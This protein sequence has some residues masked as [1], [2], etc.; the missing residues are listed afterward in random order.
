[1]RAPISS[2]PVSRFPIQRY[3]YLLISTVD[4]VILGIS[5]RFEE[6]LG[7]GCATGYLGR[8]LEEFL[9]H[10]HTHHADTILAAIEDVIA[11]RSPRKLIL[12]PVGKKIH[13]LSIYIHKDLLY[14][15]WEE[16]KS[17]SIS[18]TEMDEIGFL[19]EKEPVDLWSS[20]CRSIEKL[21]D[22]DRIF[23][24]QVTDGYRGKVVAERAKDGDLR[25]IQREFSAAFM[26]PDIIAYYRGRSFRYCPDFLEETQGFLTVQP[27]IDLVPS[28][29]MPI[30]QL[31]SLYLNAIGV[32]S[33]IS[34]SLVINGDFWGLVICQNTAKKTI[35]FQKRKLCTFIV[36]NVASRFET[37]VKQKLLQY[38]EKISDVELDLKDSFLF[39][40]TINCALV[41]RMEELCDIPHA[42][43]LALYHHGDIFT[44]GVCPSKKQIR[45]IV[46]FI[47]AQPKK[48]IFKDNNFKASHGK[49]ISG[50]LPFAGLIAL[51]VGQQEDHQMIW[52]RCESLQK[53]TQIEV[54]ADNNERPG[55]SNADRCRIWENTV[56]GSAIPWNENELSFVNDLHTLMIEAIVTRAKEQEAFNQELIS[57]NNELE[58]LTFTLSHDLRSPLAIA[59]MG[60]QFMASNKELTTEKQSEWQANILENMHSIE[61]IID[62]A[63]RVSSTRSYQFSKEPV[64]MAHMIRMICDNAKLLYQ[65][66]DC[67]INFGKLLPLW[68]EKSSLYQIFLNII[69]NGVKYSVQ[70]Q[71]PRIQIKS[72]KTK[73]ATIYMITDNGI[74]IPP[75]NLSTV[76]DVFGRAGNTGAYQ[77]TGIGL[78]LARRILNRLGG[79][80]E[81]TSDVGQGTT[82]T[83]QFPSVGSFPPTV[84]N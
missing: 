3:G 74:G 75:E 71:P 66:P 34:F 51:Q 72:K 77:G 83:L 78:S 80:I 12:H 8:D 2:M 16:Q 62:G 65:S 27:D 24:F 40:R 47:Q 20:L 52:F 13:Y 49:S 14:L 79:S 35:D 28:P 76:F 58:M 6:V 60:V 37:L 69:G 64:P 29:Y 33:F 55:F 23:V 39:N 31:H 4:Q 15:E 70:S 30:P 45:Q 56:R 19:F 84:G 46:N 21:I 5:D 82:V 32:R 17:Q 10:C 50:T 25:F 11:G 44:H 57:L 59:K 54:E 81:I 41:Q 48:P 7:V 67:Q 43:G 53:V 68:G 36:Q 9:R 1:M 26:T 22:Y 63:L 38:H 18:A 61:Q 42:D 73:H